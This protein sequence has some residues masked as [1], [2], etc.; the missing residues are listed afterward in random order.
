M[1]FKL[2]TTDDGRVPPVEYIP[3]E[4][5]T[6]KI[7]ECVAI[8]TASSHQ[9]DTSLTPTH[10]C[11]ADM[12]V[13]VPGTPLPVI[14]IQED[15]VFESSKDSS[16]VMYIGTKYDVAAGGLLVDDDGSVNQNFE[17][18]YVGGTAAGSVVRGRFVS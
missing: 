15:M 10:I 17:C 13:T 11:V 1:A 18:T 5:G 3:A 6:Y 14:R 7:G 8:D 4:A 9:L 16:N 2:Y 12:T